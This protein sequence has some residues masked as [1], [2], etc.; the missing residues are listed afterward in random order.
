LPFKCN[1]Q[2]YSAGVA[3]ELISDHI[4]SMV[5]EFQNTLKRSLERRAERNQ[6]AETE[7]FDGEE[8]EAL[9]DEQAAE[10]EVGLCTLNSFDP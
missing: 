7:D 6:R 9:T 8:M 2:R 1:L 10:D 3:G 4:V 5:A